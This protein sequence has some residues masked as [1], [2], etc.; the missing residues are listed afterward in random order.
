MK[1]CTNSKIDI[2]TGFMT[3]NTVK[4]EN[5]ELIGV[6][7]GTTGFYNDYNKVLICYKNN[8]INS[9]ITVNPVHNVIFDKNIHKSNNGAGYHITN[10]TIYPTGN[11]AYI[12]E[13]ILVEDSVYKLSEGETISIFSFNRMNAKRIYR[14]CIFENPCTFNDHNYFNSGLWEDCT[15]KENIIISTISE[16]LT[17]PTFKF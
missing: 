12:H 6:G 5:N 15:F 4:V 9:G 16:P 3:G 8:T 13:N 2:Q 10:A 7:Y 17:L 1:N 11:G 14:R